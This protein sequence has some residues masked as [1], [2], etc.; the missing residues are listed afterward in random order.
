[1]ILFDPV[2]AREFPDV[3]E[4]VKPAQTVF[5]VIVICHVQNVDIPGE[6]SQIL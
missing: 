4:S 5:M 6:I 2:D 3:D 1:L